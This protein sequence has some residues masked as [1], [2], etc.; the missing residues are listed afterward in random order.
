METPTHGTEGSFLYSLGLERGERPEAPARKEVT[1]LSYRPPA[2]IEPTPTWVGSTSGSSSSLGVGF[3]DDFFFDDDGSGAAGVEEGA[4][5]GAGAEVE[6][7]SMNPG[8]AEA[9]TTAS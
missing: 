6:E 3:L 8:G 2:A 5:A 9:A 4:G 7:D 1:R